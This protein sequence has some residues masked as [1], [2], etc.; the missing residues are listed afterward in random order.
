MGREAAAPSY[1][2]RVYGSYVTVFKGEPSAEDLARHAR[3]FDRLLAPLVE[4][5]LPWRVLEVGCGPGAFLLWAQSKGIPEVEGFDLAA[6]QVEVARRF[7]LPARRGSYRQVLGRISSWL[8]TSSS[9]S[10]ATRA[11]SCSTWPTPRWLQRGEC[12]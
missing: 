4:D 6:E 1:R 9:T 10:T 5:G 2:E 12:S 3:T 7:G 8:S 11:S